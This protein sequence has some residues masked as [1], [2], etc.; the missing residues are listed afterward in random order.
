MSVDP[1]SSTPAPKTAGASAPQAASKDPGVA[2]QVTELFRKS[3]HPT[4]ALFHVLFKGLAIVVYIL[5][6]G[7]VTSFIF[8]VVLMAFDFWTVKVS[9][10][11]ALIPA[12]NEHRLTTRATE[13]YW[14]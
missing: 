13:R 2:S 11:L 4:A 10:V 9:V 1:S 6:S 14:P 5:A 3:S 12:P 8:C 7:P